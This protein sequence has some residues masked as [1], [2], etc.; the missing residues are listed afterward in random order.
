LLNIFKCPPQKKVRNY[1][2]IV[3]LAANP[4]STKRHVLSDASRIFYPLWLL[5]TIVIQ[6]KIIYQKLWP[7]NLDWDDPL[8]FVVEWTFM[9]TRQGSIL[10]RV[11]DLSLSDKRNQGAVKSNYLTTVAVA[12]QVHPLDELIARVTSWIKLVHI[13]VYVKRIIQPQEL[14]NLER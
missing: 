13:V 7:L 8:T 14:L 6:F 5:A 9:A 12:S 11:T 1:V 2:L 3:S 4:D 10:A